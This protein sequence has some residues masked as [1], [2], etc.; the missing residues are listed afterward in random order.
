M[1]V[2]ARV[3]YTGYP[4][5]LGTVVRTETVEKMRK[6]D[7]G[8]NTGTSV[9]SAKTTVY[10]VQWDN[11]T[12]D[13]HRDT[14]LVELPRKET[15]EIQKTMGEQHFVKLTKGQYEALVR[16]TSGDPEL[17]TDKLKSLRQELDY[18]QYNARKGR[19]EVRF[20][21]GDLESAAYVLKVH[22]LRN[23]A[24]YYR[25]LMREYGALMGQASA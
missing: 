25:R 17:Q 18:A 12:E 13:T 2:G 21:Q 24:A 6:A 14:E 11:G 7:R 8:F 9:G 4:G 10:V 3:H 23:G 15:M 19:Y 22:A 16:L 20:S 5:D 1:Q